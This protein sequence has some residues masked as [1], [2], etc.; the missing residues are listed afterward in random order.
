[1]VD[2]DRFLSGKV[3]FAGVGFAGQKRDAGVSAEQLTVESCLAALEDAGLTVNDVD[4]VAQNNSPDVILIQDTL[5]IPE[6]SWYADLAGVPAGLGS[7]IN[8]SY[9]I[10]SGACKVALVYRTI[11]RNKLSPGGVRAPASDQATGEAQFLLPYGSSSASQS[12]A[13]FC[14]RHMHEF[15]T[16]QDQLG[17]I[18]VT[19]RRHAGL[20]PRALFKDPLSLEDYHASRWISRPFH[21]YDCDVPMDSSVAMVLVAP[22]LV[23][24]IQHR[25]VWVEAAAYASGPRPSWEQWD[26]MTHTAGMYAAQNLWA[27]TTVKPDDIDVAQL[28]DGFSW[29]TLSWLEDLGFCARG[30]G[31]PFI[32]E[33][34][35]A[36][37]GSLPTN[38][39]GGQLSGG[40]MHGIG[41]VAES[42]LQLR[43]QAGARQVEGARTAIMSTGAYYRA[44]AMITRVDG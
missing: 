5:G 29:F 16:T 44:A 8:A 15:G 22:E 26:D 32:E 2:R 34:H 35:T 6:L 39:D 24:A 43:G 4:G 18:C 25:P 40:R 17:L 13:M 1:V 31:G 3:A 20:N 41:K 38:T 19:Q 11:M 33:G 12:A 28:Y 37:G 10:A 21:L 9:A 7:I 23:G 42:L 36:L 30:E 14:Q 27:R